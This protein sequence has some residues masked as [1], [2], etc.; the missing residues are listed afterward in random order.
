MKRAAGDAGN[1]QKRLWTCLFRQRDR[2]R[3]QVLGADFI[4]KKASLMMMVRRGCSL[5]NTV[6]VQRATDTFHKV[7]SYYN[8]SVGLRTISSC[9]DMNTLHNYEKAF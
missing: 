8:T 4:E 2:G 7:S 9:E 5:E 6:N 3:E 1:V